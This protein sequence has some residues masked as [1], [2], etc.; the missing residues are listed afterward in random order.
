MTGGVMVS[1][2]A[3]SAVDRESEP[4]SSKTKDF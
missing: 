3:S 4:R 2:L 1:L